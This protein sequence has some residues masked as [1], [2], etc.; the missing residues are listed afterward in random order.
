MADIA[1]GSKTAV[2]NPTVTAADYTEVTAPHPIRGYR[3]RVRDNVP[4][5]FKSNY[6][7]TTY[8]TIMPREVPPFNIYSMSN[9]PS[10]GWFKSSSGTITL[11]I[12]LIY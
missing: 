5:L 1:I 6:A 4:V 3:L 12:L 2:L 8:F 11:E 9:T 7:D 10:L